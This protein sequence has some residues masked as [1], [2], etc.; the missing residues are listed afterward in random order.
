[1][2]KADQINRL[3]SIYKTVLESGKDLKYGID[4]IDYFSV[5]LS[6]PM[7]QMFR[8]LDCHSIAYKYK[9]DVL[10]GVIFIFSIPLQNNSESVT[11]SSTKI[12]EFIKIL[13]ET[14]TTVEYIK[15]DEIKLDK[16]VY[17]SVFVND[18]H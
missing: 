12:M 9:F 15:C 3:Y 14:F 11:S 7:D 5:V 13:E 8:L 4:E 17:L 18:A 10:D 2:S 16:Y 1:M 6:G